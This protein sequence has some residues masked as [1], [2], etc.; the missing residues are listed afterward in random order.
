MHPHTPSFFSLCGAHLW[1]L[2]ATALLSSAVVA[3]CATGWRSIGDAPFPNGQV[4]SSTR[5]DADGPG[6]A[7]D[8][9]VVGGYFS[10]AGSV[11]A[12]GLAG[13]D[14][15][16]GQWTDLGVGSGP[17]IYVSALG[18]LASG[19]LVVA[20][21]FS[22]I[23]GVAANCIA[24][25]NGAQWQSL[26]SGLGG[27]PF[28]SV[29]SLTT[30]PD[31]SLVVSG[32]FTTAGGL[33]A[34]RIARWHAGSWSPLGSGLS[35]GNSPYANALVAMPNGDVIAGGRFSSAGGVP[36]SG[37]AR[38]DGSSW[39]ALGAGLG[40]SF[41][42]VVLS[43]AVLG[44]GSLVVGGAFSTAGGLPAANIARWVGGAWSNLGAG[45]S[46]PV[47]ALLASG[48][49][50]VEVGG[51]F[52]SAGQQPAGAV[53]R[54]ENG[55]WSTYGQGLGSNEVLTFNRLPSGRLFAGGFFNRANG[56]PMDYATCWDGS[57]WVA[58]GP[59]L[60]SS[61][62]FEH[63][64]V[65]V[66]SVLELPDGDLVLSG[67]F[68][69]AGGVP[70]QGT[71][72]LNRQARTWTP[73]G[74]GPAAADDLALLPNGHLVAAGWFGVQRFDGIAW[75]D[76]GVGA[77]APVSTLAV[78]ADGRLVA[79]GAFLTA[80]GSPASRIAVWNGTTWG[81]LGVGCNDAVTDMVERPNGELVVA[82]VFTTAGGSPANG[83]ARWNGS[84]WLPCGTGVTSFSGLK[85]ALAPGGDVYVAGS[86]TA[87]GGQPASGVVRWDG[88]NWHAIS[89]TGTSTWP[90][91]IAVLPDGDL[92]TDAVDAT[93]RR[94]RY[95][96]STWSLV[97]AR[98]IDSPTV[99]LPLRTGEIAV[100]VDGWFGSVFPSPGLLMLS[101][102]C[103][104]TA[105]HIGTACTSSIGPMQTTSLSLP[106]LG[107]VCRT[108]CSGFAPGSL[109]FGLLGFTSPATPL[110]FLHPAGVP[111]C[112]LLASPDASVL[113]LP[114]GSDAEVG[115]GLPTSPVFAGLVL[116]LQ[117][118][119]AELGPNGL[120][121][122]AGSDG[123]QWTIGLF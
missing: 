35:G 102:S 106:W 87:A 64:Q 98:L 92:L 88:V 71:A 22:Q 108:R 41:S 122:L 18:V 81:P 4:T 112:A 66:T 69:L 123:L 91:L 79:G 109:G 100:G 24:R 25:W 42:P 27:G 56:A 85:M 89:S 29:Q 121:R 93:G 57:S 119:Q 8:L 54:W 117:V 94:V 26:G 45:T 111:G 82:G 47:T 58:I 34:N 9:L 86:I 75:A 19:E 90:T 13:F 99:L 72:R 50:G 44:D 76:L 21:S 7:P 103:P 115:F 16:T 33:P 70:V 97:D 120:T 62:P 46:G 28:A 51:F 10:M 60:S 40:A 61:D 107:S 113:I 53:A 77:P 84:T 48:A 39:S 55:A 3:Q 83:V 104:A 80:G 17:A 74:V 49:G 52:T 38:W 14:E 68:N 37:V 63:H 59:G 65:V 118:L 114:T 23:G 105:S 32:D 12:S 43:L 30:L 2:A 116:H 31:G 96:G 15:A 73:L 67:D 101:S 5:W 110:S 6:P 1:R 20:G 36:A 95:D 11:P 78:L